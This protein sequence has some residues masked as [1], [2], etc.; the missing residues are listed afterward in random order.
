MAVNKPPAAQ[1]VSS[2]PIDAGESGDVTIINMNPQ[3]KKKKN[4]KEKKNRNKALLFTLY[5][6]YQSPDIT[7]KKGNK[8]AVTA[9]GLH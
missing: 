3:K 7:R 4:K 8:R 6:R 9:A 2:A 1:S 5:N